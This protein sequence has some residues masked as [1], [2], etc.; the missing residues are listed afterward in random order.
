MLPTQ[1]FHSLAREQER[2]GSI[3]TA[4]GSLPCPGGLRTGRG[5]GL[6]VAGGRETTHEEHGAG[7]GMCVCVS[8]CVSVHLTVRAGC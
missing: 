5:W 3:S 7:L 6:L 1:L 4:L 2:P 8:V